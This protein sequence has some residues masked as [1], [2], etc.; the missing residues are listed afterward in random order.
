MNPEVRSD[1]PVTDQLIYLDTAYDG[2]CPLP[3][4]R[5]GM[6]F[7]DRRSRGVAG[8][9]EDWLRV[10]DEVRVPIAEL[11]NA[12]PSEVAITTNT[13]EGTNIVATSLG[14][15]AEDS[16]LWDDLDYPSNAVVWLS[17]CRTKGIE[18]RIVRSSQ[19][20]VDLADFERTIDPSTRIISVSQVSHQNGYVHDLKGL[21]DLAHA[22]GAYLHVDAIQAV[23]AIRVDV[24]ETGSDFLTCGTYKWLLGPMG[25]GFLYV[26]EELLPEL[27]PV[28]AGWRQV[29]RWADDPPIRPAELH[30]SARKFE[31]ASVHFQGLYELKAA[32]EYIH[33][34][35][36]DRIEEQVLWLSSRVWRGLSRQ[37]FRL[38]TPPQTSSGIVSLLP[39]RLSSPSSVWSSGQ[40]TRLQHP[41]LGTHL[42]RLLRRVSHPL[43]HAY[44]LRRPLCHRH[45]PHL[46]RPRCWE[47]AM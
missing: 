21:A 32:L 46:P 30:E 6:G 4:L 38:T 18:N 40:R 23:G 9:V 42:C 28:F 10:C 2:P 20:R 33:G 45:P 41:H 14:W 31:V 11:I 36:M 16:V 7:L 35:G 47:P 26:R 22:Q 1:F 34:I 3:V 39:M 17:L 27:D 5:A 29:K 25:L 43:R 12:K 24:K 44:H 8:R 19:G 37:G 13:T 15:N